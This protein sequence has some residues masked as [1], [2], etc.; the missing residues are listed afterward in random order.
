VRFIPG[1]VGECLSK[2]KSGQLSRL[3][4]VVRLGL[5]STWEDPQ[6]IDLEISLALPEKQMRIRCTGWWAALRCQLELVQEHNWQA[7]ESAQIALADPDL[8]DDFIRGILLTSG[9]PPSRRWA[10]AD[11][12]A[13]SFQTGDPGQPPGREPPDRAFS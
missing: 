7:L 5:V 1:T 11:G 8:S 10:Y 13:H 2:G 12:A 6:A 4:G 3:A 9:R